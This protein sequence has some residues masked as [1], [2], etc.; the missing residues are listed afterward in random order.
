MGMHDHTPHHG[1]VV[2]MVGM[3]HVEARAHPDGRVLVYLTDMWR[4]PLPLADVTGTVT[5]TARAGQRTTPLVARTDALEATGAP[6]DGD[7]VL[8][9]VVLSRAGEPVEAN[10]VLPLAATVGGAAGIP[11]AGC[12]PPPPDGE[13]HGRR[14]RCVVEFPRIVTVVAAVPRASLALI[15]VDGEGVSAWRLPQ[16]AFAFGLA[17][18]SP[19]AVP[20]DAA[21]HADAVGAIAVR[22]DG[23]EAVVSI[24]N[25]LLVY[26]A[27]SGVLARE[28]PARA[29]VVRA[30]AWSPAGDRLLVTVFYDASAHLLAAGDGRP[31]RALPVEREA[32][33]VAFSPDGRRAAVG[34]ELGELAVFDLDAERPPLRIGG[35]TRAVG[36]LAFVGDRLVAAGEDGTLRVVDGARGTLAGR[37][38]TGRPLVRLAVAPDGR[39]VASAGYDGVVRLHALPSGEVVE[40]LV[41]HR[42]V[43][44]GLAWTGATLVSGDGAGRVAV[45]DLADRMASPPG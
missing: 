11:A 13:A 28:L 31:L 2:S 26:D 6:T 38:E 12:V 32:A 41:W 4:Q 17:S 10:F 15:A 21:P 33:A 14:P 16:A 24:E 34:G 44:W 35:A 9:R 3:L 27:T 39:L 36:A 42:A 22:P 7:T 30:L 5:F 29:G 1:G 45:W 20:A 43:V 37:V 8:A 18:P 25:R 23:A 40:A 19:I